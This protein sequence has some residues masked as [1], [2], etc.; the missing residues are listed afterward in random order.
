MTII[1]ATI[2]LFLVM[3]PIGNI[4]VFLSLL[5]EIEPRRRLRIIVREMVIALAILSLFL[6]F[7]KYILEGLHISEPALSVG[8]GVVLF[9]IALRMIFPRPDSSTERDARADHTPGQ[10]P[11][12]VPLAV[13]LVAGPSAM[14]MVVLLATQYPSRVF[15]WLVAL[16]I[17][18]LVSALILLSAEV[19]RKYLGR[20]AIKALE[21]LMGMILTT[22]AVDMLLGG[23][24]TY[25]AR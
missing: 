12:L 14:A 23:I 15:H 13:P 22:L 5:E 9:L 6:F 1:S 3:D 25:L 10:E 11:L 18:W 17:A 16:L 20:R 7:G 21:R 4:P 24:E 8:G 2:T 19:L